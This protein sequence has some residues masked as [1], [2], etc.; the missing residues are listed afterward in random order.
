LNNDRTFGGLAVYLQRF[1]GFVTRNRHEP[2]IITPTIAIQP[3]VTG[4]HKTT[5]DLDAAF[6]R[7]GNDFYAIIGRLENEINVMIGV[8]L[9]D[10]NDACFRIF[11]TIPD[12]FNGMPAKANLVK[13]CISDQTGVFAIEYDGR[14]FGTGGN[15]ELTNTGFALQIEAQFFTLIGIEKKGLFTRKNRIS[16]SKYTD[17]MF[18][19]RN[20]F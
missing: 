4:P 16:G 17:R 20:I 13:G 11:I 12:H 14:P 15:F 7:N 3:D 2:D 8:F 9:I 1:R 6:D 19:G 5:I 10:L 18:T